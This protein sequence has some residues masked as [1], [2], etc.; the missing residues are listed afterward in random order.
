MLLAVRPPVRVIAA[1]CDGHDRALRAVAI[2]LAMSGQFARQPM[3]SSVD[4]AS[5]GCNRPD[6]PN[7]D[8]P[9]A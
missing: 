1:E 6:S 5:G 7:F 4:P 8:R 9:R 2:A 3:G